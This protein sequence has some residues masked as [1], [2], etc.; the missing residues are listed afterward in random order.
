MEGW[1]LALLK[2]YNIK[3]SP[4]NLYSSI[5]FTYKVKCINL[6]FYTLKGQSWDTKLISIAETLHINTFISYIHTF[7]IEFISLFINKYII[8]NT[9]YINLFISKKVNNSFKLSFNKNINLNKY[10]NT[11]N[12]NFNK[13][14]IDW[15][16]GFT[17][18]DGSFI[19]NK[20]NKYLEF[21]ITQSNTDIQILYYIKKE[22]GFGRV[23]LQD[24][25]NKTYQFIVRDKEGL[26][27]LI[28]IFNG[29][30]YLNKYNNKFKLFVDRYNETYKT[31][32]IVINNNK[33][34]SL[35]NAWLSGFTDAE[36]C[37]LHSFYN[38]KIS[39]RYVLA[40]KNEDN[41]LN[42]IAIL[43]DGK[44]NISK[45]DNTSYMTV[46]YT[47]LIKIIKYLNTY[48]LKTKKSI[49]Y[50]NWVWV[51]YTYKNKLYLK[52]DKSYELFIKKINK[53]NKSIR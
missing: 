49:I 37:L 10:L 39:I 40:Q 16:I 53:R 15:F 20:Y 19:I 28:N 21:K 42:Q 22:L 11:N 2:L 29:N 48:K 13:D 17:E 18:G 41:I 44:I 5:L 45:L 27:K 43:L 25:K 47:K 14:F 26:L 23:S 50:I 46:N 30:L 31:N 9:Y 3:K 8:Y 51:Y 32:I 36:G 38:K 1:V 34:I 12:L 35:N 33:F 6:M 4:Y 24:S 52:D 7:I